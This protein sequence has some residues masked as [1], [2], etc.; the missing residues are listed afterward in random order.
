MTVEGT[1]GKSQGSVSGLGLEH[2][3]RWRCGSVKREKEGRFGR[4]RITLVVDSMSLRFQWA[5]EVEM[6]SI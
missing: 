5:L 3:G 1:R 4:E 2:L 6:F